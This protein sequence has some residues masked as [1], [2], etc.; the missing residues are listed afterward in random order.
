MNEID[1]NNLGPMKYFLQ[2]ETAYSSQGI[3]SVTTEIY[4]RSPR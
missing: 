3:L 1:M 2:M 4:L